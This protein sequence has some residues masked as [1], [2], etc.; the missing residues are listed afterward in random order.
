MSCQESG[1]LAQRH[2]SFAEIVQPLCP[3][4]EGG[5]GEP[6]DAEDVGLC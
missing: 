3:A 2:W 1:G 4:S 5:G 6:D